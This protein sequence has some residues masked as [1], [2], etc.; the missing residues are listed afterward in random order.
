V[1]Q[2]GGDAAD[3]L[4][5]FRLLGQPVDHR[6]LGWRLA[7]RDGPAVYA[8]DLAALGQR[9]QVAAGGSR[10]DREIVADLRDCDALAL[11]DE[12]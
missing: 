11:F 5:L 1:N 2:L 6:Q 3:A 8:L 12:L 10:A 4:L 9:I 7:D